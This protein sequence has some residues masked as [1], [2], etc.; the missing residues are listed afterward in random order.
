MLTYMKG[1][2]LVAPELITSGLVLSHPKCMHAS[3]PHGHHGRHHVN[4]HQS[5]TTAPTHAG[6]LCLRSLACLPAKI[7]E[8]LYKR[9]LLHL[10]VFESPEAACSQGLTE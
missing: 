2:L 9:C 4:T 7:V 1:L 10:G 6:R 8:S 5:T 3:S